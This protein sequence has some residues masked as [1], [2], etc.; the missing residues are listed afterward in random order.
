MALV[1]RRAVGR[2]AACPA[3][4]AGTPRL[5]RR[6]RAAGLRGVRR[7]R[8]GWL[9]RRCPP[10]RSQ[11]LGVTA[12]CTP[13]REQRPGQHH[14]VG[15]HDD[16]GPPQRGER[17]RSD[18]DRRDRHDG[19]GGHERR[20]LVVDG[21]HLRAGRA[22]TGSRTARAGRRRPA[23]DPHTARA[24]QL[25]G[26]L[27]VGAPCHLVGRVRELEDRAVLVLEAMREDLE[28]H[29]ADSC[30]HR[31][32]IAGRVA[33]TPA[34]PLPARAAPTRGGTACSARRPGRLAD[35]L[36]RERGDRR[37]RHRIVPVERVTDADMPASTRP[38][39]SPGK[40]LV[41]RV[42]LAAEE[43]AWDWEAHFL[44]VPLWV[45]IISRS[46][47]PEHTRTNAIRSRCAGPCW[48]GS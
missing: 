6:P 10:S 12:G 17:L 33:A 16:A 29:P 23:H 1:T 46:K 39:T 25:L 32:G 48:P 3:T 27:G 15:Q 21:A 26:G 38:I 45:T 31:G 47:R 2:T 9:A 30:E 22:S 42:A 44:P 14:E 40:R 19:L 4:S 37:E 35:E 36:R 18:G 41:D 13:R 8:R 7:P 11:R 34:R 24:P 43:D 28:L 20:T 5:V